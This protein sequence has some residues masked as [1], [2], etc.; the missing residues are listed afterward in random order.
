LPALVALA[1][2]ELRRASCPR[3]SYTRLLT[4]RR[5]IHRAADEIAEDSCKRKPA[6][7]MPAL[8]LSALRAREFSA[9]AR[10]A[11]FRRRHPRTALPRRIVSHV[12]CVAALEIGN[13]I[14]AIVLMESDDFA[15]RSRRC[16]RFARR[17]VFTHFDA[18]FGSISSQCLL[19][20]FTPST[21]RST[22]ASGWA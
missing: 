15:I 19:Q 7:K 18:G 16:N 1:C 20:Y 2:P 17:S 21:Q 8:L 4:K 10:R 6:G 5:S 11:P 13:P 14:A 3:F 12:L 22:S 9:D